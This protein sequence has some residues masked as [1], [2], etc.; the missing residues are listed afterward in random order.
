MDKGEK[1]TNRQILAISQIIASSTLED[2]RKKA[3]ISKGTL[4]VWLK[5]EAFK[6]ELKR[7]RDEVVN[8]ALERL[9]SA[10][11]KAVTG[12]I[13]LMD[14]PRPDLRRWVYKDIIEYALK[15]IELESI[16]QRLDKIERVILERKSYK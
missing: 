6:A 12:M 11:T 16:E 15:S 14:S 10:L 5:E 7:Q 3:R 9:K 4:Y 13:D 8:E 1:L 2:A